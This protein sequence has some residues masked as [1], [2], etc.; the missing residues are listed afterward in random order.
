MS[1]PAPE[2][3]ADHIETWF[4]SRFGKT[5]EEVRDDIADAKTR[6][7]SLENWVKAHA[8]QAAA[9]AALAEQIVENID[10]AAEPAVAAL[11]DGAEGIAADAQHI[12]DDITSK[13]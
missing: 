10:P 8:Q 12:L 4:R 9:V 3:V 11:A 2:G 1:Q 6:L 13:L 7:G 5:V